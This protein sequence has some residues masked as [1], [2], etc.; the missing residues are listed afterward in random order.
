M[1]TRHCDL[2]PD[3]LI[4]GGM[5]GVDTEHKE[6]SVSKAVCLSMQGFDLVVCA[7]QWSGRDGVVLVS[8]NAP[9]ADTKGCGEALECADTRCFG[10]FVV[11]D[12]TPISC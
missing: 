7:F 8:Q 11:G 1:R 9:A 6:R 2:S 4:H 10:L 12:I 5:K 3:R